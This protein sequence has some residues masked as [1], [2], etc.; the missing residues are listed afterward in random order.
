MIGTYEGILCACARGHVTSP[1]FLQLLGTSVANDPG[2]D[3]HE[4]QRCSRQTM[5]MASYADDEILC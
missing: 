4:I 3:A 2:G 1:V 5:D